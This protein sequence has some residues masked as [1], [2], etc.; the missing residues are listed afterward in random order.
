GSDSLA[1]EAAAALDPRLARV[2]AP[3]PSF[4][5]NADA[6]AAGADVAR[7]HPAPPGPEARH[8]PPAADAFAAAAGRAG[9]DAGTFVIAY[10]SPGAERLWWL[11]RHFGHDACAV[12]VGGLDAWGGPLRGGGERIERRA[13][14]ARARDDDTATLD[15]LAAR[16]DDPRLVL[17]DT[18]VAS[19]FRGEANPIDRV[20]GRI[21]G[22][23]SAPWSE[24]PPALPGGDLVAYC[25]SGVTA[26]VV[27]HRLSLAG[28]DGRLYAG[29]WSEWEQRPEL[30]R[31]SG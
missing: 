9:V 5:P 19:R 1:G 30:P 8:P 3:L 11:L 12:L 13:F 6:L 14:V 28:R 17:V 7:D 18:R 4:V 21:P 10:G 31:A 27:L 22:A 23:V 15:E 24:P 20:P 29:S 16:L 2:A 25:G 26:C